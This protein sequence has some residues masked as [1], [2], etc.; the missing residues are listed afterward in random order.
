MRSGHEVVVGQAEGLPQSG[1][2]H[3]VLVVG[4][5]R[6]RADL[7]D[8][9]HLS[10]L[11]GGLA[12]DY[13]VALE[14][15]HLLRDSGLPELGGSSL[16]RGLPGPENGPAAHAVCHLGVVDRSAR[17]T[18]DSA[19]SRVLD[20]ELLTERA[21]VPLLLQL[22]SLAASIDEGK[23]YRQPRGDDNDKPH[24]GK[25]VD[26]F[27]IDTPTER[28][29]TQKDHLE[30]ILSAGITSDRCEHGDSTTMKADVIPSPLRTSFLAGEPGESARS[31]RKRR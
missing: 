30:T 24:Y 7:P 18:P 9:H 23:A 2:I 20:L 28:T 21:P 4:P 1:R 12:T 10:S 27:R 13:H 26:G 8:V 11:E 19:V 22:T 31:P 29:K 17:R 25:L 5:G 16:T 3:D 6:V 15:A 14:N